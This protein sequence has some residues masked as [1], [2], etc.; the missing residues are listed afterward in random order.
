[1]KDSSIPQEQGNL[2]EHITSMISAYYDICMEPVMEKIIVGWSDDRKD[3]NW[4]K[5]AIFILSGTM[6]DDQEKFAEK[7][8]PLKNSNDPGTKASYDNLNVLWDHFNG[9]LSD[10]DAILGHC[11][12]LSNLPLE[13]IKN[14]IAEY[15][16]QR[17]AN[18]LET[19]R[20]V[21]LVKVEESQQPHGM[22]LE[23]PSTTS[24]QVTASSVTQ[25]ASERK[26]QQNQGGR[27]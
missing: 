4:Y 13:E 1:M 25:L 21:Y 27:S 16:K 15:F 22:V 19:E 26:E 23:T 12:K 11:D 8:N 6:N 2:P 10:D 9:N 17:A 7:I 3:L 5:K 14:K 18:Y 20:E 24:V